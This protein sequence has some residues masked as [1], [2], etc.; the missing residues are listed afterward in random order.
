MI[1]PLLSV[2]ICAIQTVNRTD[3][4]KLKTFAL[5]C[6]H[7]SREDFMKTGKIWNTIDIDRKGFETWRNM[8]KEV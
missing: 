8:S 1:V 5:F 6:G 7:F 4:F 2:H 3:S